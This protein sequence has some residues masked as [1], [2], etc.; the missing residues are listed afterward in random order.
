[1][2]VLQINIAVVGHSRQ[3]VPASQL[4]VSLPVE[5]AIGKK[6]CSGAATECR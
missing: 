3:A 4:R 6:V 1:V 2:I 5:L